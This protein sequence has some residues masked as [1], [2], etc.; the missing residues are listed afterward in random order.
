MGKRK[1]QNKV[2]CSKQMLVIWG[3]AL[4]RRVKTK[5]LSHD[6]DS[7]PSR[8]FTIPWSPPLPV[9]AAA[10]PRAR[11]T[12]TRP[13]PRAVPRGLDKSNVN[14]YKR[15]NNNKNAFSLKNNTP[16]H[17]T[18]NSHS[19]F[20]TFSYGVR[21][22]PSSARGRSALGAWSYRSHLECTLCGETTCCSE[23]SCRR[24]RLG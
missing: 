4:H 13:R 23:P 3:R 8:A 24:N 7:K 12:L 1:V 11:A 18:S 22:V 2:Q 16:A 17:A 19:L 5:K 21:T 15:N 9:T 20:C 10:I 14:A 6:D